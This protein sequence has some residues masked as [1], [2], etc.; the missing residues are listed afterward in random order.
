MP[1]TPRTPSSPR[2]AKTPSPPRVRNSTAKTYKTPSPRVRRTQ[3][4]PKTSKKPF[5][6]LSPGSPST[7]KAKR[8]SRVK[9]S[10][11]MSTQDKQIDETF[12]KLDDIIDALGL[13]EESD[14]YIAG[15]MAVFLYTLNHKPELLPEL[16]IPDDVDLVKF[17]VSQTEAK[18]PDGFE[19]V[20]LSEA[21][22]YSL[23][24]FKDGQ[25]L[26]L[27]SNP[28]Y[29]VDFILQKKEKEKRSRTGRKQPQSTITPTILEFNGRKYKV[30]KF[31]HLKSNYESEC[32]EKSEKRT[33]KNNVSKLSVLEELNSIIPKDN[34]TSS[35]SS[36]RVKNERFG[37]SKKTLFF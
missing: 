24:E 16:L 15:S 1:R 4:P 22:T 32:K 6:K 12:A 3:S 14:Y 36:S 37:S 11:V 9:F 17:N 28:E 26:Q 8:C 27:K 23:I 19:L 5:R 35:S 20:N 33:T 10:I 7:K 34:N 29:K 21:T 18:V 13:T 25:T 2:T 30:Y 31:E